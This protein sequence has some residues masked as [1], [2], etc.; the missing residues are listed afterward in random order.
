MT[1]IVEST[2]TEDA[3]Q[4]QD[5]SRYVVERHVDNLGRPMIFGPYLCG[6][7]MNPQTVMALRAAR[8]NLECAARDAEENEAAQGRT[9][10][11][12]LEFRDQ[13]GAA[14]EAG[15]DYFFATFE[16]NDQLTAAQKMAV[17]TG[18]NRYQEAHYIQ[19]PLR[20]EVLALLALLKS[21]GL[22]DQTRIDAIT[23]AAE[24]A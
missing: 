2:Y 19:R 24:T 22:I 21:L 10:W 14:T 8:L 7:D 5:G 13:L 18:W 15:M 9:P 20:A 1:N 16:V 3:H 4:Q 23:A 12:K 6:P 17:R 11:S